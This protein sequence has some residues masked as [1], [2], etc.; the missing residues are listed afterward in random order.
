MAGPSSI[1][2]LSVKKTAARGRSKASVQPLS[3]TD[4]LKK[5]LTARVYDVAQETS[6]E[7]ARRLSARSTWMRR[8]PTCTTSPRL[9]RR[10]R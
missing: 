6:L 9:G 10:P 2:R 8:P 4:Y 7:L 3:E 1:S 5:I